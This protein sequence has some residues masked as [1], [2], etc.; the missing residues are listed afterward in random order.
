MLI[1][2]GYKSLQINI[3]YIREVLLSLCAHCLEGHNMMM[4]PTPHSPWPI[5][6]YL[7][8]DGIILAV[9]RVWL[10]PHLITSTATSD[11]DP[12]WRGSQTSG[13]GVWLIRRGHNP[14][15]VVRDYGQ[16]AGSQR[17]THIPQFT[18]GRGQTLQGAIT[19]YWFV[20]YLSFTLTLFGGEIYKLIWIMDEWIK[21][22]PYRQCKVNSKVI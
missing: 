22:L 16:G 3:W 5:F 11:I 8:C 6:F 2:Q 10:V 9:R 19:S 21:N 14:A 13:G 7:I 4:P 20:L 15:P 12:G 17:C 18:T 1:H